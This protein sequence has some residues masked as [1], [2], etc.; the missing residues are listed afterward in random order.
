MVPFVPRHGARS[1]ES[2]SHPGRGAGG[3]VMPDNPGDGNDNG[4]H[5]RI[6][7]VNPNTTGSMTE[8]IG[9]AGRGA[10]S[11]GTEVVAVNPAMGPESIEGYYD[12]AFSVP[13]LLDEIRRGEVLGFDGYVIACFDD[14]GLDAAR[15]LAAGPVLGICEA[16]MHAAT[17]LGGRFSV[18]TTLARSVPA[19]E[20]LARRYGVADRCRIRA[21]DVPVLALEDPASG[22]VRKVEDEIGRAMREDGAECIVL[23]CAGMT[24]LAAELTRPARASGHRRGRRGHPDGRGAGRPRASDEQG[25]R[26]RGPA[27]EG[28]CRRVRAV[29]PRPGPG[30]GGPRPEAARVGG[31]TDGWTAGRT[32]GRADGQTDGR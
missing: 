17:M 14:T 8:K 9:A 4:K 18:V 25:R 5:V 28:V 32:G 10:A 1:L 11:P 12:E 30:R 6:L 23:G 20:G 26:L 3:A 13:G 24:D 22:A 7:I 29:R 27:A 19:L 31:W 21:S 16:A 15:T 2:R